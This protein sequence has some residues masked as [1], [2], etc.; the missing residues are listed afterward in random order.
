MIFLFDKNPLSSYNSD[1]NDRIHEFEALF[2]AVLHTGRT[3]ENQLDDALAQQGLTMTS[4][5]LLRVLAA[6]KEPLPLY[7]LAERLA[8]VRSN[9]TQLLDRMAADSLVERIPSPKDRRSIHAALTPRGQELYQRGAAVEQ[10]LM[11]RLL[12]GLT[13]E[14]RQTLMRLLAQVAD[15]GP[16]HSAALSAAAAFEGDPVI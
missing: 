8:C 6:A 14:E 4:Y 1:M 9:V 5:G 7:Q 10:A 15:A 16:P 12:A 3:F 13:A 2:R 11:N